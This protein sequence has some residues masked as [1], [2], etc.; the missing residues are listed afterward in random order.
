MAV[1]VKR[2]ELRGPA[3]SRSRPAHGTG[4]ETEAAT[5]CSATQGPAEVTQTDGH[6]VQRS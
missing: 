3:K 5:L 6:C 2:R 1:L 4:R